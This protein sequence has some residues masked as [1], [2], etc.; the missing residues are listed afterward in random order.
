MSLPVEMVSLYIYDF[1]L[2]VFYYF[3]VNL[4]QL[5]NC[6]GVQGTRPAEVGKLMVTNDAATLPIIWEGLFLFWTDCGNWAEIN[7]TQK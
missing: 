6:S 7:I 1:M 4:Q 3:N 2:K 5:L